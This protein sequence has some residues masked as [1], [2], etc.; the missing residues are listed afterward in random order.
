[1]RFSKRICY[2]T[3]NL[4]LR[5]QRTACFSAVALLLLPFLPVDHVLHVS[6]QGVVKRARDLMTSQ[7]R[8]VYQHDH[9]VRGSA[10]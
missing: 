2:L 5:G 10:I 7:S 4:I 6:P 8:P 1:M 9:A 3:D